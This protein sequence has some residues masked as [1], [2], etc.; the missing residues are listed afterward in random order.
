MKASIKRA[1]QQAPD[2]GNDDSWFQIKK[3]EPYILYDPNILPRENICGWPTQL[4]KAV[5]LESQVS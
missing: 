2:P 1:G 5:F 3:L 4:I